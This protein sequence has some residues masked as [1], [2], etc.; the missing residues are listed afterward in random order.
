MATPELVMRTDP[1]PAE[2]DFLEGRLYEFNSRATGIVD[3]LGLAVFG[4]DT[5]G[6]L[7]AGLCGHTWGGCCEIRQVWVHERHRGHG[8]GRT[9][10]EPPNVPNHFDPWQQ[11]VLT[12]GLVLT[13]EPIICAGREAVV[14]D[15]DGW[16]LRTLDG[17][18]AAHHE[19]TLVITSGRPVILTAA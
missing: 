13:I 10:H 1:T 14:Q 5:Q 12:D 11:D 2:I 17:S 4:R 8:I 7:V 9:I 3:A 15:G 16:T 6:D 18:L 19:H